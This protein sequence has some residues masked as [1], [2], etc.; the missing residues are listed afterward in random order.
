MKKFTTKILLA[1]SS[2]DLYGASKI[3]INIIEL[4]INEGYKVYLFLPEKGPLQENDIIKKCNIN[5]LEFGV[6]RKR[7]FN[8]FGLINRFYYIIK[9]TFVIRSFILKNKIDLVY[10]NTSTLISPTIASKLSGKPSIFH[11]H[12]IPISS[13][14]YTRCLATFFNI[15]SNKVIS[16]SN[17]VSDYW[18]DNGLLKEKIIKIYNGFNFNFSTQKN[19]SKSHIVITNISRIIPYKGHLFLIE[20]FNEL[21]KFKNNLILNIIGDTLPEYESYYYKLKVKTEQYNLTKKINFIGYQSDVKKYLEKSNFFIHCPIKPD[22]LPTVVFEGI[23]SGTPVIFT[24]QG[25]SYEILDSGKNGL[26][27]DHLSVKKS[28]ENILEFIENTLEQ[29]KNVNNAKSFVE[30]NFQKSLFNNSLKTL[31]SKI[32]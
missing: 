20:L 18:V 16:V 5:I 26:L 11:I 15:F 22:P 7:Y 27:I 3:L 10:T 32:V 6:F 9:S 28:V 13:K 31:I 17:A 4:L 8:F 30:K 19:L 12:E 2:N 24:N 1:H 23:E 25:G 29:E 21:S 14:L